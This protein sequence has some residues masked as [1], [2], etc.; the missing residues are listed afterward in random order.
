MSG[1]TSQPLVR[2]HEASRHFHSAAGTLHAVDGVSLDIAQGET[3]ALVG[4]SG[5]GKTT[6]A[7]L[8]VKLTELSGGQIT[9]DGID[10]ARATRG[11]LAQFRSMVQI[12]FQDPFSSLDP[13][14]RVGDIVGEGIAHLPRSERE[15]RIA[16]L[17]D[18]VGLG[19]DFA[20]RYPHQ[21]SGGQ[22]QRVG[23]ARALA[24]EPKL[25]V[26]DEPV[27]ALDVSMQAQ[28]LNLLADLKAQ[29]GLTYLFISHD[30]SVV[31]HVA[32]RVAV[33][34]MGRI[35]ELAPTERLFASPEHPYTHALLSAVPTIGGSRR[36]R[37]V[38]EGDPPSPI[39]P[40][41]HCR[42]ASRCFRARKACWQSLPELLP[43]SDPTHLASCYFPGPLAP[44]EARR[45]HHQQQDEVL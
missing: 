41:A 39:N 20:Q 6:L 16:R 2:I 38:L 10:L 31:R 44:S 9:V 14:F 23:I 37:L 13:R 12:V 27:S 21:L 24:V 15:R 28:V 43:A 3:L 30:L 42:F 22:R 33:M 8:L 5:S 4:E 11:Q 32:D 40:P 18:K 35:V 7:R 45:Q 36:T 26:L 19:G 25:L 34:Y 29:F 1:Q 17:L